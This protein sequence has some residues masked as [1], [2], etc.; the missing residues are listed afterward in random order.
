[1]CHSTPPII[2]IPSALS[3]T[4][5]SKLTTKI[6]YK[7]ADLLPLLTSDKKTILLEQ[8]YL[9]GLETLYK[10]TISMV[11]ELTLYHRYRNGFGLNLDRQPEY[12]QW[13]RS[14]ITIW[15]I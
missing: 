8:P 9:H 4:V 5:I 13:E 7:T 1:M 2:I 10:N 3:K 15:A 12:T 14:L 6:E 11:L